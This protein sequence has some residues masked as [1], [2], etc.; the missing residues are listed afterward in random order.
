MEQLHRREE[1]KDRGVDV[2][3]S[4]RVYG[5]VFAV[6][7]VSIHDFPR[8]VCGHH[9]TVDL[10]RDRTVAHSPSHRDEVP[11]THP[12]GGRFEGTRSIA[13][14]A[15][16]PDY[17]GYLD[18]LGCRGFG[19]ALGACD[20]PSRPNVPSDLDLAHRGMLP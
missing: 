10:C 6:A 12:G 11:T 5:I 4:E 15:G 2:L 19:I 8:G 7:R 17:G 16:L 9:G 14:Q 13:R 18:H 3:L 1:V 20:Q